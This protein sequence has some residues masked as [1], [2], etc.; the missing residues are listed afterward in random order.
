MHRVSRQAYCPSLYQLIFSSCILFVVVSTERI[1]SL[2]MHTVCRCIN[3]VSRHAYC[4]SLYQLSFSS[5]ILFVVYRLSALSLSAYILSVVVSTEFL[6][7]YTVRRLS[8]E[9]IEYLVIHTVLR[10]ISSPSV[11]CHA[12]CSSLYRLSALSISSYILFVVVSARLQSFVMHTVHRCI[13]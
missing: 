9:C 12:H 11:S 8:T 7:M 1:Q 5:C 10:C 4:P 13:D 3:R 2:V 6:V